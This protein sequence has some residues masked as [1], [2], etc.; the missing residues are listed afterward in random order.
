MLRHVFALAVSAA[1]LPAFASEPLHYNIIEFS[2]SAVMEVPRDTM[3]A[4]FRIHTE[5]KTQAATN[6]EFT[7]K[8][9]NFNRRLKNSA[10]KH[11]LTGR[12][13][14]PRYQYTNGKRV[15][16]GWEESA[17][18]KV[19][20]RDFSALNRLIAEAQSEAHLQHTQFSVSKQKH[21]E[22][23]DAVSK[24]ALERFQDRARTLSRTLGFSGYK[25]VRL[26]L[27]HIGS[28][29][30]EQEGYASMKLMRAAAVSDMGAA[31][32]ADTASPGSEEISI[33]VQGTIQM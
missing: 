10:F 13:A 19:E 14:S 30:V 33:S 26:N 4:Q 8:F 25:I 6:S 3:I 11:E 12:H 28:R 17:T 15:Q 21:E 32:V 9:N 31:P 7:Q 1:A 18:F 22:T 5:G 27:G 23:V 2:E 20:S 24:A 29:S 16:T